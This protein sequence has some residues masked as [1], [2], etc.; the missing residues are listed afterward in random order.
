MSN[1]RGKRRRKLTENLPEPN[2]AIRKDIGEVKILL[3]AQ[4]S[5]LVR[6]ARKRREWG[7]WFAALGIAAVLAGPIVPM[8]LLLIYSS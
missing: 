3:K 7:L 2:H 5:Y 4:D 6:F 8:D 1:S